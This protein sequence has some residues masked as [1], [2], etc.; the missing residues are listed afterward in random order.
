MSLSVARPIVV[1]PGGGAG[2]GPRRILIM[3]VAMFDP[4]PPLGLAD[5]LSSVGVGSLNCDDGC[6]TCR[7]ATRDTGCGPLGELTGWG[8]LGGR[9][10]APTWRPTSNVSLGP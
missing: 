8:P 4:S 3:F 5:G 9:P 10:T 1:V 2:A 7:C 6:E